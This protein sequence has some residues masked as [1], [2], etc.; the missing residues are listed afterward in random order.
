M[1]KNI[2]NKKS[3]KRKISKIS[4][5][6][7]I[8]NE[9]LSN[10]NVKKYYFIDEDLDW[11]Y[12]KYIIY[13]PYRPKRQYPNWGEGDID[14]IYKGIKWDDNI[15]GAALFNKTNNYV[16]IIRID[17]NYKRN[18]LGTFLHDYIE[19]DQKIVLKPAGLSP[20]GELFWKYRNKNRK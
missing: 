16:E 13:Y 15:I 6:N 17:E 12:I 2:K 20:E 18:G 3:S 7:P 5:K 11:E 10:I 8:N 14:W 4:R 9:L 1:R 19:Q